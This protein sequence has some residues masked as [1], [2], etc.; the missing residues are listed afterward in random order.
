LAQTSP[1]SG[2]RLVG[3][4]RLRTQATEFSFFFFSTYEELIPEVM[5]CISE[6]PVIVILL[7]FLQFLVDYCKN[8]EGAKQ[9]VSVELAVCED[10][11]KLLPLKMEKLKHE[12]QQQ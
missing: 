6:T 8:D 9:L 11:V 4:V 5:L 2:G 3:I 12:V 1:T 7:I 10:M